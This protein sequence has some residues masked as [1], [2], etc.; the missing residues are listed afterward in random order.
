MLR[1]LVA[2]CVAALLAGCLPF[3]LFASSGDSYKSYK[4]N[5]GM[6]VSHANVD[7]FC[8]TPKL[9]VVIAEFEGHFG[10]KVVL[11][12][13][14]RDPDYNGKVGGADGSYHMKCMAADFFIPGVPKSKLIA[15]AARTRT[16]GGLGCYPDKAFIH[17]DVRDRPRGWDRPV[18]FAGC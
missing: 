13:G 6:Y 18:T 2:V 14:Y 3:S 16:V 15:F 11:N 9:R 17:V 1:A 5:W 8:L 12:S 7:T 4:Q 10:R